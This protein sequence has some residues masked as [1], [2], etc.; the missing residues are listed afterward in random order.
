MKVLV[1]GGAGFIGSHL[2]DRLVARGDEVVVADNMVLGRREHLARLA[3]RGGFEL[4]EMDVAD[5]AALDAHTVVRC[6][7]SFDGPLGAFALLD[8]ELKT[9]RTHQIRVH[10]SHVGRPIVGDD[11]DPQRL[12]KTVP[13]RPPLR[14]PPTLGL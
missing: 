2:C 5:A 11:L 10:L 4:V 14:A 12:P 9:G 3:G 8:V 7:E 13:M 6:V 1:T